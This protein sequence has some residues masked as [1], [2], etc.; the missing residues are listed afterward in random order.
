MV[1]LIIQKKKNRKSNNKNF[2]LLG[3]SSGLTPLASNPSI[4]A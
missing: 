4:G 2:S 3:K 1:E